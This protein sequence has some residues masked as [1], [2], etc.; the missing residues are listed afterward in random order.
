[1]ED[2]GK[3]YTAA[4]YN[5]SLKGVVFVDEL[6][7]ARKELKG[8]TLWTIRPTL[9]NYDEASGK[10]SSVWVGGSVPVTVVD[11]VPGWYE[12]EPVRLLLRG[13]KGEEG[14]CDVH[15][16]GTNVTK[17]LLEI[18]QIDKKLSLSARR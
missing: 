10:F 2:S 7:Q 17:G 5:G 6:E 8:K 3:Q 14:Y 12:H 15:F 16:S 11:V 13:P 9:S 4:V 18:G 1:M